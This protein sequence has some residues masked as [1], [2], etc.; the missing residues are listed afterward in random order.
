MGGFVPGSEDDSEYHVSLV[1]EIKETELSGQGLL[2][3]L[4]EKLEEITAHV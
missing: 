3:F 4:T 2:N 1:N